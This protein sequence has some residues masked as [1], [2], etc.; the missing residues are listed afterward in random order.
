MVVWDVA[1][2]QLARTFRW[3]NGYA[4]DISPNGR[5]LAWSEDATGY[6]N[7]LEWMARVS[8]FRTGQALSA[9]PPIPARG[10]FAGFVKFTSQGDL[11]TT[12]S[13]AVTLR[14]PVTGEVYWTAQVAW[15]DWPVLLGSGLVASKTHRQDEIEIRSLRDGTLVQSFHLTSTVEAMAASHDG[16]WIAGSGYELDHPRHVSNRPVVFVLDAATGVVVWKQAVDDL[17]MGMVFSP[18]G[19]WLVSATRGGTVR[20]WDTSRIRPK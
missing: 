3:P 9:L 15:M 4:L 6:P 17:M 14:K 16:R 11:L 5:L 19:R 7:T 2:R 1:T 8:D 20:V 18:D 13:G 12:G 10:E